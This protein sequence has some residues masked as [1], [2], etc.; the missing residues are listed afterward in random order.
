MPRPN[1]HLVSRTEWFL[2][3]IVF[4]DNYGVMHSKRKVVLSIILVRHVF[5]KIKVKVSKAKFKRVK[6]F[7]EWV[8]MPIDI[9]YNWNYIDNLIK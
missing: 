1:F 9:F 3:V 5:F 4:L 8:A 6:L 2:S 7:T